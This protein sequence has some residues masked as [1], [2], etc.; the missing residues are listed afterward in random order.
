[1]KKTG[2]LRVCTDYRNMN[3]ATPNDEYLMPMT[4]LFVDRASK[5]ELL[6]FMGGYAGYNQIIVAEDDVHNMAFRCPTTIG[7]Y[8]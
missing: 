1:M 7:T 4:N 5:H 3:L 6:F 2:D 8:E